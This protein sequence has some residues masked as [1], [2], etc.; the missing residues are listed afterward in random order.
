MERSPGFQVTVPCVP[1]PA[2]VREGARAL[3]AW[4]DEA[5]RE[6]VDGPEMAERVYRAM[7]SAGED[8]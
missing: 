2:Q 8:R 5:L 4:A 7:T 3:D 1:T 6:M